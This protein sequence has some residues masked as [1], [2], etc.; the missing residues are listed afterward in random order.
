M[1]QSV[2]PTVHSE[3]ALSAGWSLATLAIERWGCS[4]SEPG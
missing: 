3:A 4:W 2:L 1:W